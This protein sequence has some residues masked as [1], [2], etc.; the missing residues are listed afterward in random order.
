MQGGGAG[1]RE[2][3]GSWVYGKNTNR[4]RS[5]RTPRRFGIPDFMS[6]KRR[7]HCATPTPGVSR[8]WEAAV[9]LGGSKFD[10]VPCAGTPAKSQVHPPQQW[11]CIGIPHIICESGPRYRCGITPEVSDRCDQSVALWLCL[12]VLYRNPRTPAK[13]QVH[14][15]QPRQT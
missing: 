2:E 5:Q 9:A 7:G 1:W 10:L 4:F 11:P 3:W 6:P 12:G 13:K 15:P 14:P 8:P